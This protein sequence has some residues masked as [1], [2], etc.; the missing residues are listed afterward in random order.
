[1]PDN[2]SIRDAV[3][4]ASDSNGEQ[5]E[6]K[7][8]TPV[9]AEVAPGRHHIARGP[10]DYRVEP[11]RVTYL[12]VGPDPATDAIGQPGGPSTSDNKIEGATQKWDDSAEP[13]EMMGGSVASW[14]V[15]QSI[16]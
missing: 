15:S 5:E 10:D 8:A 7:Q 13:L 6:E 3:A 16:P 1:M 12:Y 4:A 11:I 9:A 14:S 2:D